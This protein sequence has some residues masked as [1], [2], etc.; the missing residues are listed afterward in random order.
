MLAG[1]LAALVL[2]D[3]DRSVL[4]VCEMHTL[5]NGRAAAGGDGGGGGRMPA[6]LHLLSCGPPAL[7]LLEPLGGQFCGDALSGLERI[8]RALLAHDLVAHPHLAL[9]ALSGR[10]RVHAALIFL[11]P[12][13]LR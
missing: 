1:G 10:D 12:Q 2:L 4:L 7:Q 6:P 8:Q 5:G 13:S 9:N 3:D 11:S